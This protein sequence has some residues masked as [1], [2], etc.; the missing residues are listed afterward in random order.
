MKG[1]DKTEEEFIKAYDTLAD[2]IFRYCYYRVSDRDIAKDLVQE[3]FTRTWKYLVDEKEIKNMRAFLYRVANNLVIE[4]YRKKKSTPVSLD[5]LQEK[6]FDP[7]HDEGSKIQSI[8]E[9][10]DILALLER[11][12]SQNS[13]VVIMRYI[14]ELSLKEISEILGESENTISVRIHRALKQIRIL[15]EN[16]EKQV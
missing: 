2:A 7:G 11:L 16:H 8:V 4:E 9:G 5:K 6:G 14:N 13:D 15:L 1:V 10:K 12:E 3:T